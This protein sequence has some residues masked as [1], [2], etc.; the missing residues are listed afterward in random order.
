M[1][2]RRDGKPWRQFDGFE[3]KKACPKHASL[4]SGAWAMTIKR[5]H[6]AYEATGQRHFKYMPG[7][8]EGPVR[9]AI[10]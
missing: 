6:D 4:Q 2:V 3:I 8:V 7:T 5:L 1:P 10:R 9:G